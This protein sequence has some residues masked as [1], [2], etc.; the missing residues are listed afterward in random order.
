VTGTAWLSLPAPAE[1]ARAR[2][3]FLAHPV[4]PGIL[5]QAFR[6][7]FRMK[8]VSDNDGSQSVL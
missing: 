4:A 7:L 3:R 5:K 1:A 6:L 2:N 8:T